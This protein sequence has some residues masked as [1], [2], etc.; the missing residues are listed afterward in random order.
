MP[1][2]PPLEKAYLEEIHWDS[3]GNSHTGNKRG[4]ERKVEV[5]FN[6][7]TLKLAFSNQIAGKD[8]K[9]GSAFQFA[10]QG[11][12]KLNFDLWFDVSAPKPSERT[13]KD[14]RKLTKEIADFMKAAETGKKKNKKYTPPGTR[15]QWGSFLFEGVME[16]IN[17]NLDFFS[18]DGHPLR[19]SLSVS[20]VKQDVEVKI[21]DIK[22]TPD[23]GTQS[24]E[25]AKEG[26]TAQD[27]AARTGQQEGWQDLAM[28][29]KIENPRHIPAGT[30]I[31]ASLNLTID[32]F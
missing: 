19:A 4:G 12:T 14:V 1:D 13:E 20:L 22:D 18:K 17:E 3:Q 26:E 8:K 5:Q 23:P 15:F 29:N 2:Q 27:I 21:R 25:Q 7:E 24:L 10:S 30:L 9:G 32:S 6:P 28:A 31:D 11:S 16:S